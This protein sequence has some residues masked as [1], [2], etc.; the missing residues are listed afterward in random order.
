MNHSDLFKIL[1]TLDRIKSILVENC[2]ELGKDINKIFIDK[3]FTFDIVNSISSKP[4][5]FE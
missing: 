2:K 5:K 4:Q 3:R 1:Q